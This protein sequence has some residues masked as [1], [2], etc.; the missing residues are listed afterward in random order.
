[1]NGPPTDDWETLQNK[2]AALKSRLAKCRSVNVNTANVKDAARDT[3]RLYF[4]FCRPRLIQIGIQDETLN[5]FDSGFQHLLKLANGNNPLRRYKSEVSSLLSAKTVIDLERE[6]RIGENLARKGIPKTF[7]SDQE[8]VILKTLQ[9]TA[10]GAA[11]SYR[12]ACIDLAAPDRT[13]FRG[14]ANEL[15]ET[16]R[17]LLDHL[18]K[19]EDVLNQ[20]NFKLE[21][22]RTT[23]IRHGKM[24]I[25]PSSGCEV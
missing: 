2:L 9:E 13:A 11:L 5:D 22:G 3:V 17:E 19:D 24:S 16:L 4:R 12:Q 25:A 23:P 10:P 18:A 7:L 15:R 8:M 21:P 14:T 1:M 20:P 6:Q